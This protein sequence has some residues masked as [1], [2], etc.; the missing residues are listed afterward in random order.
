[1]EWGDYFLGFNRISDV[2]PLK[3]IKQLISLYLQSN[4]NLSKA[5]IDQL[6]KALL[7]H[8]TVQ[9]AKK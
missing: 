6:Q 4:P 5:Q 9:T 3:E 2:N 1:M 7:E 8:R